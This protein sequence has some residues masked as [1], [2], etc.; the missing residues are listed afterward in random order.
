[1]PVRKVGK[2]CYQWGNQKVYC[3]KDA[4]RK[5]IL[6]GIAIEN[7]GWKEAEDARDFARTKHEGRMYG[8]EPYMTHIDGV[9]SAFEDEHLKNIAYLH[10]VVED[11]DV[12]IEDIRE[13]FGEDVSRA[14]DAITRRKGE[15]YFDYIHRVKQHPEATQVKLADLHYNLNEKTKPSLAKRNRKA[16]RILTDTWEAEEEEEEELEIRNLMH[17]DL[18]DWP[19]DFDFLQGQMEDIAWGGELL[20]V[21]SRWIVFRTGKVF[22]AWDLDRRKYNQWN[23]LHAPL[24]RKYFDLTPTPSYYDYLNKEDIMADLQYKQ[25]KLNE[26]AKKFW[27]WVPKNPKP[28]FFQ[29]PKPGSGDGFRLFGRGLDARWLL[30]KAEVNA[31]KL[32]MND[33]EREMRKHPNRGYDWIP[34]RVCEEVTAEIM[35]ELP[36]PTCGMREFTSL[37]QSKRHKHFCKKYGLQPPNGFFFSPM[38]LELIEEG[39]IAPSLDN[40]NNNE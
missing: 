11:T 24:N 26:N 28:D 3:G 18:E 5:A 10:D 16:I 1:M 40:K 12:T 39:I 22:K 36:C 34:N 9:A 25:R 29:L 31:L 32:R 8:N 20:L 19:I 35:Q 37:A 38:I 15:L 4:K 23:Y 2:D 30:T 33:E 27:E 7:T 14:V 13:H 17:E 6:Q 21:N